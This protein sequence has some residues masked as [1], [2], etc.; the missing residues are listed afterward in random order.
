MQDLDKVTKKVQEVFGDIPV[1]AVGGCVRDTLLK[2]KP[3]DF[4]YCINLEPDDIEIAVKKAGRRA[5]LTGKRFGTIGFK[6]EVDGHWHYIEVTT[7]RK[8]VYTKGSR[9]PE[10][11]FVT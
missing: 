10:V 1:Y 7:F 4:D 2:R 11:T 3:K 8:E 9:K 6:V 5:Y